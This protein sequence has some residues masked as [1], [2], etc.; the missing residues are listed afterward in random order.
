MFICGLVLEP[1][2]TKKHSSRRFDA[3]LDDFIGLKQLEE[4][5]LIQALTELEVDYRHDRLSEIDYQ[6]S[7]V[8]LM[9]RMANDQ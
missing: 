8:E 9:K 4:E 5:E 2:L 1:L 3:L 6:A 7:R